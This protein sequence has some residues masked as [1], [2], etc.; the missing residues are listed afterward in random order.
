MT[1]MANTFFSEIPSMRLLHVCA[2]GA[3]TAAAVGCSHDSS[4]I[5]VTADPVAGLRYI[6]V[7]PDT[8]GLDFRITDVVE[9]APM[10]Y[11][12]TFRTGGN[13]YGVSTSL[14][15][16]HFAVLAG[17]R[18]IRV[19]PTS[20]NPDVASQVVFETDYTFV[21]GEY[22][23]VYLYGYARSTGNPRVNVLITHDSMATPAANKIGMRV[24]N[25]IPTTAGAPSPTA[26]V[27]LWLT[28]QATAAPFAGTA[29]FG[30]VGFTGLTNYVTTLDTG[31]VY[32][33]SATATGTNTPALFS[34]NL[35]AG[36]AGTATND[37]IPGSFIAGTGL[38]AVLV[39][40]SVAGSAAP[41]T[42][43]FTTPT[44]LFM[45]DRKPTR[46]AP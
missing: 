14:L 8:G 30:N 17:T 40:Q 26:A 41:Q 5:P 25:L 45:V 28:T 37:P 11:N 12:A 19:F 20:T 15:P 34:A 24:L 9:N 32:K 36:T 22:Y 39:P 13:P 23:T 21:A 6:N 10:T 18:H 42:A 2:V 46:T 3:L 38:T 44:I 1:N 33:L 16:P 43:A 35:S 7:V 29:T 4:G 27:D 31:S